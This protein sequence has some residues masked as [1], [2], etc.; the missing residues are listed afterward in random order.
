MRTWTKIKDYEEI[1][2]DLYNGIARI[3]INRPRFR[4]AFTPLTVSEMSDAFRYCATHRE[5]GV[6]LL[7]GAGDKAFCAGGDMHVK[8]RGGYVDDAGVPKLNVLE[9]QKQ[10]P[11]SVNIMTYFD[12]Q[13]FQ[14]YLFAYNKTFL[15]C[16][17]FLSS[18]EYQK[19]CPYP[20]L[21][22][23]LFFLTYV[24]LC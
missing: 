20:R 8:G 6:V 1:C 21:I 14:V 7:T 18:L 2:F 22:Q 19:D 4:N 24:F 12:F 16:F 23:T 9:V 3:T 10:K 17:S 5:V 11:F 15:P 13:N